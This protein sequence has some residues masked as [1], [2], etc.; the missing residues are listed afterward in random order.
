MNF[1]EALDKIKDGFSLRLSHW[2]NDVKIKAQY[3]DKH[4]KMTHE[5]LYVESAKG[6]VPW[7]PTQVEIFSIEWEIVN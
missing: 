6:N 3:S 2:N 1:S 5:Y 4:S 7:L